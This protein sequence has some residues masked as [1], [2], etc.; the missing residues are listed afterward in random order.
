MGTV[1]AYYTRRATTTRTDTLGM[2]LDS[3]PIR[4]ALGDLRAARARRD[5]LAAECD[6]A[7]DAARACPT[8]PG[9]RTAARAYARAL[10]ALD[11]ARVGVE[12]AARPVEWAVRATNPGATEAQIGQAAR[13][14]HVMP[15][16]PPPLSQGQ[17]VSDSVGKGGNANLDLV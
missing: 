8:G 5:A 7:E 16:C 15:A 3:E 2:V 4:A 12:Y 6:R 1:T 13:S 9:S 14:A 11:N 17:A 10:A